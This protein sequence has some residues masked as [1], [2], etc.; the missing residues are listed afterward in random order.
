MKLLD[1][2]CCAGGAGMGCHRAGFDVVGVDLQLQPRYPFEF[3]Q[4]DALDYLRE[5]GNEFDAIHASPPCQAHSTLSAQWKNK[6]RDYVDLIA[7]TR[8]LLIALGKPYVIENVMGA[9]SKMVKPK[10]LCGSMF[11]ELKVYR[12]RLF[13]TSFDFPCPEHYPHNDNTPKS[14]SGGISDKGYVSVAGNCNPIKYS[15]E[16]MGVSWTNRRELSESIPP[17]YTQYIGKYLMEVL[18]EMLRCNG[19][20]KRL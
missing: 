9:Q 19:G 5:H 3:F 16:A 10:M 11:A 12:H 18:H 17:P 4:A 2:F 1:L 14:G 8:Q 15:R 6:G 13:E 7:P 20:A